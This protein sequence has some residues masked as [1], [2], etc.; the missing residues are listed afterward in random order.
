MKKKSSG[1][2]AKRGKE[3]LK[4]ESDA[5]SAVKYPDFA[6]RIEKIFGNRILD[7]DDDFLKYRHREWE[8]AMETGAPL[9]EKIQPMPARRSARPKHG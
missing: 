3:R 9:A 6:A 4:P 7:A 8:L 1:K 5:P 2:R